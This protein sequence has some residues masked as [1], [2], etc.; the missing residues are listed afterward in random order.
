M[1]D[2]TE[3]SGI[4]GERY[5]GRRF[6]LDG[7]DVDFTYWL[8]EEGRQYSVWDDGEVEVTEAQEETRQ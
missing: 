2:V 3:H 8:D 6:T 4:L 1:A 7:G 5:P